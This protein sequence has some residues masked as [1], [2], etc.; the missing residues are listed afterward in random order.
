VRE[1]L[2]GSD[3]GE[4]LHAVLLAAA[5]KGSHQTREKLPEGFLITGGNQ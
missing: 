3:F 1:Y 2:N 4:F 5:D